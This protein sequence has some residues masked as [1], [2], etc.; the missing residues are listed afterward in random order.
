MPY[1]GRTKR[2]YYSKALDNS[3]LFRAKFVGSDNAAGAAITAATLDVDSPN[4]NLIFAINGANEGMNT[5]TGASAAAGIID[6]ADG[7]ADAVGEVVDCIN[8]VAPGQ[9]DADEAT[10][11]RRWRAA[12]AD[13][14]PGRALATL[15]L[16]DSGGAQNMLLGHWSDGLE[17]MHDTSAMAG[18][19]EVW[20]GC[21]TEHRIFQGGGLIVPDYFEDFPGESTTAG[22]D[23]NRPDRKRTRAKQNDES[24]IVAPYRVVIDYIFV[25]TV[26]NTDA[27]TIAVFQES[28]TGLAAPLFTDAGAA[29]RVTQVT[30]RDDGYKIVGPPGQALF[31]RAQGTTDQITGGSLVV[32]GYIETGL[33][34]GW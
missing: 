7:N 14:H 4:D 27:W 23:H 24:V 21:G 13:W 8:G 12:L 25:G 1:M 5:Y 29:V 34:Q 28:D 32:G 19:E 15:A 22:W 2:F 9:P 18:G 31:V 20:V 11:N 26:W 16:L 6:I 3:I 30:G 17:V 33:P 10:Y